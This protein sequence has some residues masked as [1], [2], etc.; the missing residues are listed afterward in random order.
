MNASFASPSWWNFHFDNTAAN[1]NVSTNPLQALIDL[2]KKIPL[3]RLQNPVSRIP[4]LGDTFTPI[5][6]ASEGSGDYW[7]MGKDSVVGTV[8]AKAKIAV[9]KDAG[10]MIAEHGSGSAK[11]TVSSNANWLKAVGEKTIGFLGTQL[12][13]LGT[14]TSNPW[15]KAGAIAL[16]VAATSL[17]AHTLTAHKTLEGAGDNLI[18]GG[19]S[20]FTRNLKNTLNFNPMELGQNFDGIRGLTGNITNIFGG[21]AAGSFLVST[22]PQ[23]G[24]LMG[25]IAAIPAAGPLLTSVAMVTLGKLAWDNTFGKA[26]D[27]VAGNDIPSEAEEAVD[28]VSSLVAEAERLTGTTGTPTPTTANTPQPNGSQTIIPN[29]TP[30]MAAAAATL[31]KTAKV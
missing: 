18:G 16:G 13:R 22:I 28:N 29:I 24:M 7:K 1:A 14:W 21:M 6:E 25:S 4:S 5:L 17:T 27:V 19:Q 15:L 30:E 23:L 20:G 9:A 10:L 26:V 12:T 2:T 11:A 31:A 3:K 8:G